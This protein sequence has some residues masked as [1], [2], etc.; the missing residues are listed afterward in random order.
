MTIYE[1]SATAID[2]KEVSLSGY[3]GKVMLIVNT[4]SQCGYTPQY[5]GRE[6]LY[7][8]FADQGLVILGF[9]CNQFGNQEPG[10]ESEI[11]DFCELNY[12]VSFPMFSKIKVNGS[13]THPLYRYLK[14]QAP[15]ILG[16]NAVKW[17][18][19]KFLVNREGDVV[20]R[21][22]SMDKPE[23]FREGIVAIL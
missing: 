10:S 17:N 9:P 21:Y 18:F 12:A 13:G 3:Q 14:K 23:D 6:S 8:E 15:G 19:S 20:K 22:G 2:G 4:A 7:Q 1:Y 5:R 16:F 11:R